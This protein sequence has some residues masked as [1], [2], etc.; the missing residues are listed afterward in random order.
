MRGRSLVVHAGWVGEL[1]LQEGRCIFPHPRGLAAR[2]ARFPGLRLALR[3]VAAAGVRRGP[4]GAV[5][6]S[7]R[8]AAFVSPSG[9]ADHEARAPGWGA[10]A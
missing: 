10:G 8:A 5:P 9:C 1:G 7:P 2:A 3:Y 6:L 4:S